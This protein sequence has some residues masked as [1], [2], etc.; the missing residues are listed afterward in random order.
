MLHAQFA[1]R[2]TKQRT[3]R[4]LLQK[5]NFH[6][7]LRRNRS[8][9]ARP[10]GAVLGS[11]S[12]PFGHVVACVLRLANAVVG[13]ATKKFDL[14]L[15]E[16]CKAVGAAETRPGTASSEPRPFAT[17]AADIICTTRPK[18]AC[19]ACLNQSNVFAQSCG[20]L[21]LIACS[22]HSQLPCDRLNTSFFQHFSQ[23]PLLCNH[24]T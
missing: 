18:T 21:V 19:T 23:H 7:S 1:K 22:H 6:I 8:L 11:L 3:Q 20:T 14:E 12:L 4:F 5:L 17:S 13:D 16:L 15:A 2:H 9:L 24:L 10:L